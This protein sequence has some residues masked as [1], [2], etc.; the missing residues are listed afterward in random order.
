MTV[1]AGYYFGD[2]W[3]EMVVVERL[4]LRCCLRTSYQIRQMMVYRRYVPS[5]GRSG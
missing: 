2:Q 5:V 3:V 1:P 4:N